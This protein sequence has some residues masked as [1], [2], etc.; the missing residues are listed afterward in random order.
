MA[1]WC[2]AFACCLFIVPDGQAQ[3][4]TNMISKDQIDIIV[5]GSL[6][7]IGSDQL[8]R[9]VTA[10]TEEEIIDFSPQDILELSHGIPGV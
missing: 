1:K 6:S 8:S 9:R 5:S 4:T 7:P 10:R 2:Y 3:Q